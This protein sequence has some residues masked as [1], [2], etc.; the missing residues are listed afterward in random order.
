MTNNVKHLFLYSFSIC[1][2][3]LVECLFKYLSVFKIRLFITCSL[4]VRVIILPASPLKK[5][6][7]ENIFSQSM[8]YRFCFLTV[9]FNGASQ[10]AQ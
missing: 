5:M 6:N 7:F 4:V 2:S 3:S 1:V 10:V 9:S 8:A